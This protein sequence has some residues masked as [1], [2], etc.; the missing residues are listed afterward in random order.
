MTSRRDCVLKAALAGLLLALA[1]CEDGTAPDTPMERARR[2]LEAGD[3]VQAE[4]LLREE[5]ES[6]ASRA[7]LAAYLG[8]AALVAGD[9]EAARE[10]LGST[11]FSPATRAHGMR[12]L[13]RLA[14][15]EGDLAAAG[16]AFDAA[17]AA[18]PQTPELWVDIGR[19]RYRG[20]EQ[21]EALAAAERAVELSPDNP[22]ALQFR[23]QLA[24]DAEGL[25]AGARWFARALELQPGN[26]DLRADY[27]ATLGDAGRAAQALAV[28]RGGG[29]DAPASPR[30]LYLLAVIAARGGNFALARSLL[31]RSDKAQQD[32]PAAMLL[33][34]IIDLEQDNPASASRTLDR[35]AQAQPDNRR[36][37]EL[38]AY[39]LSRA[40][41]ERELVHRFAETASSPGAS[42][43]LQM[44]VGR[45]YETLGERERAAQFL[46]AA[47]RAEGGLA[48]LP[49]VESGVDAD[50]QTGAALRDEVR[51]VIAG[52]QPQRG[53]TLTA[54]FLARHPGSADI[55]GL[56][57]DAELASGR[58]AAARSAYRSAASIRQSW[59]LTLRMIAAQD[60]PDAAAA[61]LESYLAAYPA[62]AQASAMLADAAAAA[63]DWSRAAM[64]LDHAI[65]GGMGRVPWVLAA[66]SIAARQLGNT[67]DALQFAL[68]AHELQPMNRAA[69]AAL[70]AALPP[71]ETETRADLQ[72]KLSALTAR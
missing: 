23:G 14:M 35:L 37:A 70:L 25:I 64:L 21:I 2:T 62:N 52:G 51:S 65:A 18:G 10:W 8:E 53:A 55:Y 39:A 7:E 31:L 43:Y 48:V 72:A 67:E 66:R 24:R 38:L 47:A 15:A 69:I 63:S 33:S 20:G 49:P 26:A 19:L 16:Q 30:A 9:L 6:G 59:P 1:G 50:P 42:A 17:L 71:E 32:M 13:G 4:V 57:G 22:V 61:V 68:E 60:D 28:L 34:A 45:A 58:R 56:L 29:G 40:G 44:L 54:R 46:D 41:G 27:A 3:A 36:V 11:E 5:L 12:M